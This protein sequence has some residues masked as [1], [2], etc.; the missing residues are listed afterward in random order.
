LTEASLR[1]AF[2]HSPWLTNETE[3]V[4]FRLPT[5]GQFSAAV[6]TDLRI[7]GCSGRKTFDGIG[8]CHGLSQGPIRVTECTSECV[9]PNR[10]I[11]VTSTS[12]TRCGRGRAGAAVGLPVEIGPQRCRFA[13]RDMLAQPR[14]HVDGHPKFRG[15]FAGQLG[16]AFTRRDLAA[17]R[18]AS[19][20]G[21]AG[22]PQR[23]HR[24]C[25]LGLLAL[26]SSTAD[27][28][29]HNKYSRRTTPPRRSGCKLHDP[30][31]H[32][33]VGR[34]AAVSSLLQRHPSTRFGSRNQHRRC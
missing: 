4:N 18:P 22:S 7:C 5:A 16:L 2:G 27:S 6:D 32:L 1:E 8:N 12:A 26:Q 9:G 34:N 19:S 30:V 13:Q 17:G 10:S 11:A 3:L 29:S 21:A 24:S 15:Q 23:V 14:A 31:M 28:L 33:L 25:Q 20:G